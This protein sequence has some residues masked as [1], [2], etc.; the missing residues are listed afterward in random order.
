M[1]I[2]GA[3]LTARGT[4]KIL[5]ILLSAG[6]Q[7]FFVGGCV[8]NA[9]LDLAVGDIDIAT[10]ALP[11]VVTKIAED[12]GFRVVPTGIGHGTVTVIVDGTPH[13]V[14]TLRRDVATDGRHAIVAFS[15]DIAQDA[16]RRDFTMNAL[17]AKADGTVIDPLGGL[18]DLLARRVR[19]VGD[20]DQRIAEDHLRI[21]RF[22]RFH[23]IY[24]DPSQ[25]LD[26][27][28][29]AACATGSGLLD[30]LSGERIGAEI[31]KLLGAADPAPALAAMDHAGILMRI[32]PGRTARTVP[33]L[34]HLE[35]GHPRNWLCRLAVLGL[36]DATPRL[37]MSRAET[38]V[39]RVLRAEILSLSAP[40]ALGW[41]H[42]VTLAGDVL[43]ARAA[44]SD[45]PL[46]DHWQSDV[47]RGAEAV[48]PVRS[49]DLMPGLLGRA[50]GEKLQSLQDQWLASG[51]SLTR[52]QLLG[53]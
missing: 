43:H 44:M 42:G 26:P 15:T 19:F 45:M 3:W 25:G 29:L 20:P 47:A 28:G 52:D 6:H 34:V 11:D 51:L 12:A 2:T 7:A 17:Y 8:R 18:P 53:G 16:A 4:Q 38:A 37:R 27:D 49:A 5:A 31:R 48:F 24:G 22:F 50:L 10:D 13:E 1:K 40:D 23:A 39:L 35:D 21:L 46:P 36:D 9:L 14:T 30:T 32:L 33:I 41:K